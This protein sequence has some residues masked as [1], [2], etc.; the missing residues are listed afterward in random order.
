MNKYEKLIAKLI[1]NTEK[2]T[3]IWEYAPINLQG[4]N[5]SP[6][7]L[8]TPLTN[9]ITCCIYRKITKNYSVECVLLH[10]EIPIDTITQIN[11]DIRTLH[12]LHRAARDA[13][14]NLQEEIQQFLDN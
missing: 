12:I 1:E 3:Q 11:V 10:K 4:L 14:S 13:I 9:N 5:E 2:N 7:L 8:C 6:L